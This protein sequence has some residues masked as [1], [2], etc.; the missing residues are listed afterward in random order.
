MKILKFCCKIVSLYKLTTFLYNKTM[1]YKEEKILS[2]ARIHNG[3][4]FSKMADEYGIERRFIKQLMDS[5]HLIK[6]CSATYCLPNTSLDYYY[7]FS[8]F[9]KQAVFDLRASLMLHGM[10]YENNEPIEIALPRGSNTSRYD[11][12]KYIVQTRLPLYYKSGIISVCSFS[13]HEVLTYNLPMTYVHLLL[14][15]KY[16]DTSWLKISVNEYIKKNGV[17]PIYQQA[18]LIRKKESIEKQLK[19][20]GCNEKVNF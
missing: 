15:V 14:S 2:I 1:H 6:V 13:N 7:I 12:D 16:K 18:I 11:K 5:N 10:F 4:F 20:R 3:H 19:K 9:H 8:Y 17:E